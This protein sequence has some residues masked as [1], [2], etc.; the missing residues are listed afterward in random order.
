MCMWNGTWNSD[1]TTITSIKRD[2]IKSF[3]Q[4]PSSCKW[5]IST[6]DKTGFKSLHTR[7]AQK[8][9]WT[10]TITY[11]TCFWKF[12]TYTTSTWHS[13]Q[14]CDHHLILSKPPKN[15]P[16]PQTPSPQSIPGGQYIWKTQ[17]ILVKIPVF[18][19]QSFLVLGFSHIVSAALNPNKN[20][21]K[22]Y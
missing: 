22:F 8:L 13:L 15:Y 6:T 14:E 12:Q 19:S 16:P 11:T 7:E 17:I 9:C 1:K 3:K 21:Q 4:R 10:T 18:S 20:F 2:A 5:R